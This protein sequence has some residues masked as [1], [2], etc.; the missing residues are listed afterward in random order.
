M[1]EPAAP[2]AS[3]WNDLRPLLDREIGELPEKYRAVLV[4][5]DL[6]GRSGKEAA[7]ELGCPEGTVSSR[8]SRA[9]AMLADRLRR[10]GV[11]LTAGPLTVLLSQTAASECVP[12]AVVS[13][14]VRAVVQVAADPTAT[15]GAI[16]R[17]VAALTEGVMKSMSL[18]K[19]KT[20]SAVL[21]V[22]FL[23]VGALGR[24]EPPAKPAAPPADTP[25]VA[26]AKLAAPVPAAKP[27]PQPAA[28]PADPMLASALR[29]PYIFFFGETATSKTDPTAP[30]SF[31]LVIT[32]AKNVKGEREKVYVR[33][34]TIRIFRADAGVDEFTK[35]GWY[36]TCGG[37]EGQTQFKEPGAVVMVVYQHDG[38]IQWHSLHLDVRC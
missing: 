5:C 30:H 6:E 12:A 33:R 11:A 22:G 23:C 32:S 7:R 25:L 8:L 4:L 20:V 28:E 1:P 34:G 35:Q 9:R 15:L 37:K 3:V 13:S 21:L 2:E 38:T 14:T 19:L 26:A 18:T 31:D 24:T 17:P 27:A 16:S 36:W 29:D 10:H